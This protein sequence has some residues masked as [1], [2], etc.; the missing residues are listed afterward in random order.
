MI[1]L[2]THVLL[3]WT[4][5]PDQL[6]SKA[7][8]KLESHSPEDILVNSFSFWEI[9]VKLHK[10]KMNIGYSAATFSELVS[11][12]GNLRVIDTN[13]KILIRSV[14]LPWKHPDPIDRILVA[15]AQEFGAQFIT[16][17]V[18]IRKFFSKTIW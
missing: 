11:S 8:K 15:T 4:L 7:I 18:Q 3:W 9:A 5:F 17:D 14:G 6:S 10:K 2:D 12:S 13:Y 1:L 16:K